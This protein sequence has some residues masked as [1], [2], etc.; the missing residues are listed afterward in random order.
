MSA[1][2][3][4]LASKTTEVLSRGKLLKRLRYYHEASFCYAIG[5]DEV[6]FVHV[7]AICN[8]DDEGPTRDGAKMPRAHALN[9]SL[10]ARRATPRQAGSTME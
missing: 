1:R 3:Q 10:A 7:F 4:A 2:Y 8:C 5:G 9:K 6:L